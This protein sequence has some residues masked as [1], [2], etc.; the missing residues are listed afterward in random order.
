MHWKPWIVGAVALLVFDA[1]L[2]VGVR[3]YRAAQQHPDA[4]PVVEASAAPV[5]P[6]VPAVLAAP[7]RPDREACIN[8]QV[9][10]YFEREQRW[11]K[12]SSL[13]RCDPRKPR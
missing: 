5:L 13:V 1:V 9:W 4:L 11:F 3:A 10:Q 7:P 6:P 2:V 8:G 12:L